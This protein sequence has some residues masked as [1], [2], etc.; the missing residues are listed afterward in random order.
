MKKAGELVTLCG[1][2]AC[3]IIY[4]PY[5]PEPE[6]WPSSRGIQGT[7]QRFRQM[8]ELEQCKKM[9]NQM[10]FTRERILKMCEQVKK[11]RKNNREKELTMVMYHYM[12]TG[13]LVQDL[14]V[15]DFHDMKWLIE[16]NLRDVKR[17]MEAMMKMEESQNKIQNQGEGQ[18]QTNMEANNISTLQRQQNFMEMMN[19]T[20]DGTLP[21]GEANLYNAWPGPFYF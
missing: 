3:M 1:V 18:V 2:E 11:V 20:G 4:S 6:V 17:K 13:I 8:P 16:H 7:I 12:S 10:S 21:F 15:N 19:C 14:S 9:L 5:E